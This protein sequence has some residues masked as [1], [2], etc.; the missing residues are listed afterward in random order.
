VISRLAAAGRR[1]AAASVVSRGPACHC[2][3]HDE[4]RRRAARE[5]G[6]GGPEKGA[7]HRAVGRRSRGRGQALRVLELLLQAAG[8]EARGQ[9]PDLRSRRFAARLLDA[10]ALGLEQRLGVGDLAPDFSELDAP[11]GLSSFERLEL[12]GHGR[13]DP[14]CLLASHGKEDQDRAQTDAALSV[15]STHRAPPTTT[16][17]QPYDPRTAD[18]HA[19]P[20][21]KQP[22]ACRSHVTFRPP[23]SIEGKGTRSGTSRRWGGRTEEL[24]LH[25][26]AD[27][28]GQTRPL[29]YLGGAP[30]RRR[31]PA[32]AREGVH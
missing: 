10:S 18:V 17:R 31:R 11:A 1:D 16:W 28:A 26:D 3:T 27:W 25:T 15:P 13:I 5:N 30:S 21:A 19:C 22:L 24:R 7:D 14:L 9:R 29:S 6:R 4:G 20:Q 2:S 12:R 8:R 32:N 23:R